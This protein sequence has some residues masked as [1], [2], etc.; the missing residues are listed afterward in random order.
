VNRLS[1]HYHLKITFEKPITDHWFTVKCQ[2][3]SD[4]RQCIG[5]LKVSVIPEDTLSESV[6]SFG[7]RC[8]YGHMAKQHRLFEVQV[9][10]QVT[11][12]ADAIVHAAMP[13]QIGMFRSH[14]PHTK[15]GKCLK[16]FYSQLN[17]LAEASNLQ[18]SEAIMAA[19]SSAF[20][21]ET[22]ST[23]IETTAEAAFSQG[24]G[25]CQ[26]Y[27]HIMIALCRLSGIPA[28]YV[29]GMVIGEGLSHAW[30]EIEEN[31]AWHGF[32]PTGNKRVGCE[33]IKISHGRD[34]LDCLINQGFF[35]GETKQIQSV[36][37]YV[38]QMGEA[39]DENTDCLST[40][41]GR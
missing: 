9:T 40:V 29:V 20:K 38:A 34:Y 33:H 7:N 41:A 24:K 23:D 35:T 32:D 30:V 27:A 31:G 13:Y 18:K 8:I 17:L 19:L 6:D 2:P 15:P 28:R 25:V 21:Y 12:I 14:T 11:V 10:G 39:L 22:A 5:Q 37:A 4:E 1:F 36:S 26:D 16:T 3:Q